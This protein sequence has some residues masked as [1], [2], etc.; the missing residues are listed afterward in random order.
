MVLDCYI[1][2]LVFTSAL[3]VKRFQII[4]TL[5]SNSRLQSQ[6]VMYMH[7]L[8]RG[9]S[10]QKQYTVLQNVSL[11]N[12]SVVFNNSFRMLL[13]FPLLQ[14]CNK[15]CNMVLL[16]VYNFINIQS[17]RLLNC[18]HLMLCVCVCVCVCM[19]MCMCAQCAHGVHMVY[20]HM[21]VAI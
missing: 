6:T 17:F 3:C 19:C 16:N 9:E 15:L 8:A 20:M 10:G 1:Y 4:R 18:I 13:N 11:K 7:A 14:A 5:N 21:F 12:I 2:N